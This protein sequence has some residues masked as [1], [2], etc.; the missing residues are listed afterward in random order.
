MRMRSVRSQP[1]DVPGG[2]QFGDYGVRDPL[3]LEQHKDASVE[4]ESMGMGHHVQAGATMT[5]WT[6]ERVIVKLE[7]K[8]LHLTNPNVAQAL[9]DVINEAV[10]APKTRIPYQSDCVVHWNP[11]W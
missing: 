7:R 2:C 3:G 6:P 5:P 4:L 8:G 9:A 1:R 10:S 11:G